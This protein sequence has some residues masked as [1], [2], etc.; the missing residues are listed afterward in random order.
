[1][2]STLDAATATCTNSIGDALMMASRTDPD[3]DQDGRA[4]Y[5]VRVLEIPTPRRTTYDAAFFAVELAGGVPPT[6]QERA[7][8]SPNCYTPDSR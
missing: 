8:T 7:Y 2:P 3:F 5:F 6:H 4:L 1:M